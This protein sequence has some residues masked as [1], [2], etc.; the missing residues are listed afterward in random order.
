MTIRTKPEALPSVPST[1]R[2]AE[3]PRPAAAETPQRNGLR[4]W[5]VKD[6][7]ARLTG[8]TGFDSGPARTANPVAAPPVRVPIPGTYPVGADIDRIVAM[9]DPVARNHAITQ[10]YHDVSNAVGELLG[11]ENAN[12]A[13]FGVWASKQAGQTIRK[14][15]APKLF[16]DMLNGHE[17][18]S[19]ALEGVN[20]ALRSVGLPT[21]PDVG[22]LLGRGDKLMDTLSDSIAD[23]NR[24]VFNEIAREFSTFVETFK[25]DTAYN[26]AKVEQYLSHFGPE[27]SGLKD[28]F[29]NY[30]QAQFEKNP[31]KKAELMLLANDQVGLHEQTRLQAHVARAMD[32]PIEIMVRDGLKDAIKAI[33]SKAGPFGSGKLLF[34]A[35]EKTGVLDKVLA[36][37]ADAAG[38]VWRRAATE[39]MMKLALP[40]GQDLKLG[41]DLPGPKGGPSFPQDLERIENPTLR[42]LLKTLDRSEDSLQGSAAKDWKNLGDRMN[43]ITDLFRSYQ[44]DPSLWNSPSGNTV[45]YSKP[46]AR[47]S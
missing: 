29:A 20:K 40:N 11:K 28:A 35:L 16:V 26:P 41:Q 39:V 8:A 18:V 1:P 25:G 19:K 37:L 46:A 22:A 36:P 12:W 38:A 23:G 13:T 10:G 14:E 42:N 44:Q 47:V 2:P 5:E 33:A 7:P 3:L 24:E 30:A 21:I 34:K 9:E 15:D 27:Q 45:N 6:V 31:E 32:A 4:R 17:G 43:F